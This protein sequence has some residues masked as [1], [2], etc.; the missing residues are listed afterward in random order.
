MLVNKLIASEA[1]HNKNI[2]NQSRF[3]NFFKKYRHKI[4]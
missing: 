4:G 3:L 2:T 1:K